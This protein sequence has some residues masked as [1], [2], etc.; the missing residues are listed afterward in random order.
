MLHHLRQQADNSQ[1]ACLCLADFI[2]PASSG[3]TDYIGGFAVTAG[4]VADKLAEQYQAAGDD[5]HSIMV[6][7]LADRLAE[8]FAEHMHERVRKEF[9]G[10]DQDEALSNDELIRAKYGAFDRH[11]VTLP[12][13]TILKKVLCFSCWKQKII[14]VSP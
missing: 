4:I 10:Y 2:A 11:R 12:A 5:Y 7:A 9:W 8:A 1:K 13:R 3:I 14:L 6:K